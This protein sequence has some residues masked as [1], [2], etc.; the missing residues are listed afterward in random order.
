MGRFRWLTVVALVA[1]LVAGSVAFAQGPR[2]GRRG[3][4]VGGG[5]G[6]ELRGLDLT[7]AQRDQIREIVQRY[8]QQM[9]SDILLVLTPD[10]Q[11]KMKTLEAQR[12]ARLKERLERRQQRQNQ[13]AQPNQQNQ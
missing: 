13:P 10:Q 5:P 2:P 3:G 9:R 12:D 6:I 11:E 1:V 7:D 4:P 8:Q